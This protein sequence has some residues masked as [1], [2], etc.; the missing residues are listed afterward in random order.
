MLKNIR[1]GPRQKFTSSLIKHK[2]CRCILLFFIPHSIG[3]LAAHPLTQ[4]QTDNAAAAARR[5]ERRARP[6]R[7]ATHLASSEPGAH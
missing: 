6:S 2:E 7:A 1:D 4:S 5:M 3:L